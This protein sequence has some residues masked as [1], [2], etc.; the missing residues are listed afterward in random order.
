MEYYSH[1]E[2]AKEALHNVIFYALIKH[3]G[4]FKTNITGIIVQQKLKINIYRF[5]DGF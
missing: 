2:K 3:K 1:T 5:R 4:I